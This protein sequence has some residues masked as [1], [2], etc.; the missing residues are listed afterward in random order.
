MCFDS[1]LSSVVRAVMVPGI[2]KP[3]NGFAG[4]QFG[5]D[6]A[7]A[8]QLDVIYSMAVQ[9]RWNFLM[10]QNISCIYD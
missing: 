5:L 8:F 2:Q 1:F 6:R 10:L 9:L 4:L 7:D 3:G